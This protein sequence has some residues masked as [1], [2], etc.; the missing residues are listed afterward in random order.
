MKMR[1]V[2]RQLMK[3]I[4]FLISFLLNG[5]YEAGYHPSYIISHIPP[6]EEAVPQDSEKESP[7]IEEKVVR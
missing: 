7:L 3:Y 4:L 6:E 5:C 1:L 2:K